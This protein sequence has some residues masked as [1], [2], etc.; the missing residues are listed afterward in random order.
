[1]GQQGVR[2]KIATVLALCMWFHTALAQQAIK[3]YQDIEWAKPKGF[4]LTT[5]IYVPDNGKTAMPVLIILHGGGWLLNSKTIMQDL[6]HYIAQH[7][8]YVVVNMN[9]RVLAD[10]NNTTTVNEI[11][12]DAM[13]A[14]LWVKYNIQQYQG[15]PQRIA[16]TGDSAGGHLA[17]MVTLAGHKLESDG[18]KGKSLGFNPSFLPVGKSAEQV[19]SEDGMRVQATILSYAVFDLYAAAKNGFES[20]S[21]PF[22]KWANASPRGLFGAEFNVNQNPDWYYAVSPQRYIVNSD[23]VAFSPQFVLVGSDDTMT[24]PAAS[25][26]YVKQLEEAGQAATL[27]V[28]PNRTH[29][30]LDSGCPPYAS[31]CF[32]DLATPTVK[33]MIAFLDEVLGSH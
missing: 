20:S 5:D 6:A 3:T 32:V 14:V 12:E 17:A 26:A 31:G 23:D 4:S 33:D 18:F 9:Y 29:G 8:D 24:P 1:M 2:L 11:V 25:A 10:L 19:A 21:N 7:A 28:Y 16:V 15:D 27:K 13:G 22:W 30:F